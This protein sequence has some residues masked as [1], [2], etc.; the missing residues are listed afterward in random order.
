MSLT[1]TRLPVPS[2]TSLPVLISTTPV[3]AAPPMRVP[4]AAPFPPLV[5]APMMAPAPAPIPM[6]AASFLWVS[7]AVMSIGLVPMACSLPSRTSVSKSKAR[8]ARVLC[9]PRERPR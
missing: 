6:V 2:S 9:A 3:P 5:M 7:P 4:M 8:R 1:F